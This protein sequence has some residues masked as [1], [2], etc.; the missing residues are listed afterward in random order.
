M[1][2]FANRLGLGSGCLDDG[3]GRPHFPH[4]KLP[5]GEIRLFRHSGNFSIH[6]ARRLRPCA[7]FPN[8]FST[9]RNHP[10]KLLDA[11]GIRL[12]HW[13]VLPNDCGDRP[14]H[15]DGVSTVKE[16]SPTVEVRSPMIE[17][18]SSMADANSQPSGRRLN[19]WGNLPDDSRSL[20]KH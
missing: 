14:R 19:R 5:Y 8:P 11:W 13:R 6:P 3:C 1:V 16:T 2:W 10:G 15:W 12:N 20:L 9:F 18:T 7:S 4:G 17:A